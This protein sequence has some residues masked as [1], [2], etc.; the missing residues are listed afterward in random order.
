VPESTSLT[1]G[2]PDAN[3]AGANMVGYVK[4]T[5]G[6][7]SFNGELKVD[8]TVSDVRCLPGA[9]ASVCNSP[10]AQDG[11]DYSGQLQANGTIRISDHYNGPNHDEAATVQDIPNPISMSCVNTSDTSTGAVCTDNVAEICPLPE[12]CSVAG[13][14]TVIEF[15][16]IR[17]DDGG[18]DGNVATTPNTTFLRQGVFIP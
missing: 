3:G 12:G 5:V 7:A 6:P 17:V 1:V 16:Q 2:T 18:P 10:N 14:R 13:R 9:A 15:G 8:I 4:Y 11:P